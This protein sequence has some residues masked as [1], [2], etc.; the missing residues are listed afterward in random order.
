[1]GDPLSA[2]AHVIKT[3]A[4]IYFKS[5]EQ[6]FDRRRFETETAE[7]TRAHRAEHGYDVPVY[8][9]GG[10]YAVNMPGG[11]V[12][13]SKPGI[14]ARTVGTRHVPGWRERGEAIET[15]KSDIA[16]RG[17]KVDEDRESRLGRE[18]AAWHDKYMLEK[19]DP[20][21][22]RGLKA[23]WPI[24]A[25]PYIDDVADRAERG[26]FLN[27]R[28]AYSFVKGRR[29]SLLRN[30]EAELADPDMQKKPPEAIEFLKAAIASVSADDFAE[31][32]FGFP[33]ER[34]P[35]YQKEGLVGT[36]GR[37]LT[38]RRG[39]YGQKTRL[40][41]PQTEEGAVKLA[42]IRARGTTARK[43]GSTRT[44][45][46]GNE[47]ITEEWDGKVWNEIGRGPRFKPGSETGQLTERDRAK[48]VQA[49]DEYAYKIF[50]D[51]KGNPREPSQAEVDNLKLS[52]SKYG[53]DVEI[54]VE[55][56]RD[57]KRWW[58][59]IPFVPDPEDKL[60]ARIR[61]QQASGLRVTGGPEA[62]PRKPGETIDEYLKRTDK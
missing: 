23:N 46:R 59:Y 2:G 53:Y 22:I 49:L 5:R 35:S 26:E 9:R 25:H 50:Y 28:E 48:A 16:E 33:D 52:A 12:D 44:I 3:L 60:S 18:P 30:M 40:P 55:P 58:H 7:K 34:R 4:D 41:Y 42:G 15:R 8:G 14:G 21:R 62:A 39:A 19:P 37:G 31:G 6:D 29:P 57:R 13:Y 11:E 38:T 54:D 32:M 24:S 56:G 47:L 36:E 61:P 45:R 43:L 17:V 1:M 20:N 10:S 27:R 51:K